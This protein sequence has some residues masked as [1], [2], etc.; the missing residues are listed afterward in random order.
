MP[1]YTDNL[2]LVKPLQEETYDVDVFNSNCDILDKAIQSLKEMFLP[3]IGDTII[4]LSGENPS[5]RYAG[6]TWE[7][8][9]EGTFIQ[10]AGKTLPAGEL[11][12]NMNNEVTIGI[13]N[14]PPHDH[15]A[16]S[17]TAGYHTHTRGTMNIKGS[18]V[19]HDDNEVLTAADEI[20]DSGALYVGNKTTSSGSLITNEGAGYNGIYFDASKN[21]TGATSSNGGHEHTITIAKTGGGEALDITPRSKR[22]YIWVRTA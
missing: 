19:A 18:I 16:T 5:A 17:S 7:L 11:T 22:Y 3:R 2:Q 9:E 15:E 14:I 21:W 13:N 6:T 8:Q 20:T 4:T 1:N 12:G 10:A